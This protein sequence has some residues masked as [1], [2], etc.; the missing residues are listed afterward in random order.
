LLAIVPAEFVGFPRKIAI[1][2]GSTVTPEWPIAFTRL[3]VGPEEF[4]ST[5][6]CNHIHGC[7][8]DWTRELQMV[9]SLLGFET[10]VYQ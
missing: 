2:K 3:K 5:F 7:Y 6:P 1:Q 10:R 4:L 9:G 8:G